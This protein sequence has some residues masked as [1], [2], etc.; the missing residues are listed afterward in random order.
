MHRLLILFALSVTLTAAHAAD[1]YDIVVY[2]GTSSGVIAAIQASRMGRSVVLI[3]STG[4]LGGLTTGGLGATDI[5]NKKAIGGIS[6][7][8]YQRVF[9]HYA[10][11][12]SWTSQT[13]DEYFAKKPHG[14]TGDEDTMWTFEPHVATAIYA[15]MIAEARVPVVFNERLDLKKGVVKD[16]ARITRIIMESGR[17]FEGKVFID[18]TYEGDLMARA[19]VSYHVGREADSVY[20]ETINGVQAVKTLSHQ[21]TKNVDPYVKP[22][23]SKSG[24]LHGIDPNGPGVEFNGD[25]RIQAYNYRMCTTS[26][27]ENRIDWQ[28]PAN[29]DP[30]MFELALRNCEAGDE[31]ISWAPTPMPNHKTDTNNNF[32]VSTDY[33]GMNYGYPDGDYATREKIIQAHKDWQQGLM[34]TYANSPRVPEKIRAAFQKLGLAKDEFADSGHWPRQ[35]YV[36]EARR[37]I[38]DYVMTEKNCRR[39]ELVPDSVGMGAYNMDSHNAQRYITREGFVRNEGDVQVGTRPY[40]ISYRSLRPKAAECNNLLVPV[41]LAASHIAYGSIRM[42]P[43]FMVLGQSAATAAAQAIEQGTT[44]QGIDDAKLKERLLADK[45]MLDFESPPMAEGKGFKAAELGGIVVDDEQ[46]DR[47]GFESSGHNTPPFVNEGYRHDNNEGK[48]QQT[49]RFTPDLPKAGT[50]QV[51]VAY[52]ALANRATNV[53]VTIHSAD[54]DKKVLVNERKKGPVK[55]LLQPVG[56]YR[57][58]AGKTGWVEISN[59]GTDGHVIIDAVQWLE[60]TLVLSPPV[61][62]RKKQ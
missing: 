52:S 38:S 44:V 48:G 20:D 34:W 2:G 5:G 4:F 12:K 50:Y 49:A 39:K 60:A 3:E 27:P 19:G 15:A 21:F 6:R 45:Q 31:R 29:Y 59:E 25:K 35:L 13:R 17:A 32:A 55:G 7:E 10:E 30:A 33:I 8:F 57:F 54:G 14:N 36:R 26:V 18:A 16:G 1:A 43:V 47:Q 28:K 61:K 23:D 46:A 24:V 51:A 40:P 37:M 62:A 22:G 41:C 53:P 9:K 58:E 42:E 56:T 11:P